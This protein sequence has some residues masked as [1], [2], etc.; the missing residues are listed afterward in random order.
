MNES[1]S[2]TVPPITLGLLFGAAQ[3]TLSDLILQVRNGSGVVFE[4]DRIGADGG[5]G[6]KVLR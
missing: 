5:Q 2:T 4:D 3:E 6:I 1:A